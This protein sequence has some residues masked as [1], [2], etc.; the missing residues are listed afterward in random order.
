MQVHKRS[1]KQ[2]HDH[3][4]FNASEEEK[5]RCDT[6]MSLSKLKKNKNQHKNCTIKLR[7]SSVK[8]FFFFELIFRNAEKIIGCRILMNNKI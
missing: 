8:I 4:C 3:N 7:T 2:M 1:P 5:K 6:P